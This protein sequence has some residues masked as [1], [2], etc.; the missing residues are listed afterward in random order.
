[1]KDKKDKK[2][3]N[4]KGFSFVELII[5]I[6][7]LA[8]MA[9]VLAPQLIKYIDS[10]RKSTDVQNAQA[11]ATA[12][13]IALADEDAY[14]D[15]KPADGTVKHYEVDELT[16][17]LDV[18]GSLVQDDFQK[19]VVEILGTN[20][21]DPKFNSS[22]NKDFVIIIKNKDSIL[23]FYIYPHDKS[24]T[25]PDVDTNQVDQ[26]YPNVGTNYSK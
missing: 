23:S 8:I 19:K 7:I 4:N 18:G 13:N 3:M 24:A 22:R 9:G 14:K 20:L 17:T 5:A 1:M 6:A 25:Y 12:V 21:P 15:A 10:S 11:I 2:R 16:G 26:L